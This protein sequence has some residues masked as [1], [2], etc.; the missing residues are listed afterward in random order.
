M[1]ETRRKTI[2]L[3]LQ[4]GGAHGAFNW[5]VL[6]R[7]L[8]DERLWIEG[9]SGTSAG[10]MNAVVVADGLERGGRDGAR[11]ALRRFWKAVSDAARFSPVQRTPLDMMMGRWS[12][13][14][15]PGYRMMDVLTRTFSPYDLN[16]L[17]LNPLRDL[18]ASSIDFDNVNRCRSIK[19]FLTATNVETGR[20][21]V[22]RQP[23]LSPDMVMA[24]ACLPFVYKAVEI[25]GEYF[26][27][28]GYMGNP[29][30]FPL[31]DECD[32]RDLVIVQI[33]PLHR[34]GPP[35]DAQAI[36]NRL[37]EITFN[38]AL[39][40]ELRAIVLLKQLIE[41]EGLE[42]ERY[43][44]MLV[45]RIHAERELEGLRVS[46]KLNA[47][48]RFLTHL[49]D[50]GWRTAE[51]WLGEN[52]DRLGVESTFDLSALFEDSFRPPPPPPDGE[53]GA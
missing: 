48:W 14:Y 42:H 12:L 26:W 32:A 15:S 46:S 44:D 24:S 47:E 13:D 22:F 25:D 45:H 52:F 5:G 4:G 34:A 20:A 29:A 3:A 7:L 33:N 40:K 8:A 43:R 49:H 18:V 6:D 9:L 11:Q 2:E 38:A 1:A 37:N 17:D 19:V 39:I 53:G 50:I 16:P 51:A 23:D 27:D 41:A 21:K 35:T 28:G 10:A 30:L 36:L 31:V